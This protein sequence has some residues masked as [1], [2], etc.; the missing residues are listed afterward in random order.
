MLETTHMTTMFRKQIEYPQE[1]HE[2]LIDLLVV[3]QQRTKSQISMNDLIVRI[4]KAHIERVDPELKDARRA[5]AAKLLSDGER[6]LKGGYLTE[7]I[8][9]HWVGVLESAKNYNDPELTVELDA[10]ISRFK[11]KRLPLGRTA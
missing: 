4:L 8:V 1:V 6:I 5:Y 10:L 7:P 11:A 2:K 3:E 9:L